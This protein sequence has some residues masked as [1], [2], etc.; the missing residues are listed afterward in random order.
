VAIF[1]ST[2]IL[3]YLIDTFL[4]G[5]SFYSLKE[6][7]QWPIS[8]R[9]SFFILFIVF[10]CLE[11]YILPMVIALDLT[12]TV[13]NDSIANLLGTEPNYP[14]ARMFGF[15]FL[16]IIVWIVQT[17]MAALIGEKLVTRKPPS[18]D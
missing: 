3:I 12:F 13:G 1:I 9:M 10:V 6:R 15:D 17:Q 2:V 5:V 7:F 8:R 16:D 18:E 14:F 4:V 11:Y